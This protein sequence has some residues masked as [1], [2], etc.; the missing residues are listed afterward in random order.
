MR[1]GP[2][3]FVSLGLCALASTALA[4]GDLEDPA[5]ALRAG[6]PPARTGATPLP[7]SSPS[8]F[9][10]IGPR[11]AAGALAGKTIYVSAGHGWVW[12]ASLG[13]WRA[14][15]GNTH[16]LVEDFISTETISQHL[17]PLLHDM[18]A[19]VV[20]VREADMSPELVLVDDADAGA[21]VTA[22]TTP[23]S[24]G[25]A[26]PTLPLTGAANP[27]TAG[28][29]QIATATASPDRVALW[30]L[31]P[32]ADLEGLVYLSWVQAA[33][34]APDAHYVIHHAGG[35]SEVRVDQRRHGSTWVLIGS[36][37]F[38]ASDPPERRSIE[39]LADSASPGA[40]LSIDA[41]RAGGGGSRIDRGQGTSGRPAF[42]DAAR[43]AAQWNGAPST[44]WD[45]AAEDGNDD[46]GTRSRFSA[47]DH[48]TGEDAV[49]VAWHTNAPSPARGTSSFAYGPSSFGPLS[50]FSG[51]P[52]SLQLM[53]AIHRELLADLRAGWDPA[54]QDR[55]QHTAYF[56]EVNPSHNPEMPATLIEVAFHDTLADAD[57]LR[58]PAFRHLAARAIAQ[59]IARYFATRDGAGL[60]LPPGAPTQ[61]R[62]RWSG[63]G[64]ELA[65]A[66]PAADPAGGDAPTGY[67]VH[68]S[69]DGR[70][71][72]DGR[73]ADGL[74][75]AIPV[76]ELGAA[77][78][79]RIAAHNGGGRSRPS[80]VVGADGRGELPDVL[81]VAGFTR[82]DGA[83]LFRD[84]LSSRGLGTIDRAY[85]S[86]I[87]DASHGGRIGRALGTAGYGYAV[88]S[89]DA[90]RAGAV[91][92]AD[93]RAVVWLGGEEP[94]PLTAADRA[95]LSTFLDG[96]GALV[97][98]GV[99]A[100]GGLATDDAAFLSGLGAGFAT[101]DAGTYSL[102]GSGA[103][104]GETFTFDDRGPG[105]YDADAPDVLAVAG[106]G[107]PLL[108][109][110]DG[111]IA[112]LVQASP[113][114]AAVTGFPVETVPT[115]GERARILG[116]ALAGAGVPPEPEDI[117]EPGGCC[118]AGGGDPRASAVL[119]F[120]VA[121]LLLTRGRRLTNMRP[122]VLRRRACRR[123]RP[124]HHR[125]HPPR[126]AR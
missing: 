98:T 67:T 111:G 88:A 16:S 112:A 13:R 38:L 95:A 39:L 70:A 44:V 30:T 7:L 11:S 104:A 92:L 23:D 18:G 22:A 42:E 8:P 43:Y 25:F 6:P 12:D 26:T 58:E 71:F 24:A 9:F 46:V 28:T 80:P 89:V 97:L 114:R 79:A 72:D 31:A 54:W 90:V 69:S 75:L 1:S 33:D 87:N 116:A 76:A 50:E 45:Y 55:Q 59:G 49:Y 73:A 5:I 115:D 19:Y 68:L 99:D 83:M 123:R 105:G 103:L 94:A 53:D 60:T 100:A 93:Y 120:A 113:W 96:G 17:I 14:Q 47:W 27:F 101:D 77:R 63:G 48:E 34:R 15:R 118:G 52:G 29:S 119:V 20:P 65:W 57:A 61:V 121:A 66:P 3:S 82:L 21:T 41:V 109:S 85:E 32:A 64:L 106:G 102:Q 110:P 81:V 35:D 124:H 56:G 51:V 108:T 4:D 125:L 40:T 122:H 74:S 107:A 10:H 37:R 86:R 36:Y 2:L 84:D 91:S 126:S 62:A 117:D 78:F